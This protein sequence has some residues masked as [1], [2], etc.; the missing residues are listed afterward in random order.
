LGLILSQLLTA[1]TSGTTISEKEV[2][3]RVDDLLSKMTLQEKINQMAQV[4]AYALPGTP[5]L[6]P[7]EAALQGIGSIL[8][9]KDPV[10][11]NKLQH[12]AVEQSRMH[13][14]VLF[15]LDVI[16][17]F[18]TIF[19]APLTMAASWD[20]TVAEK[21]QA[22]AAR[23]ARASGIAWTFAPMVDIARD[24][25]WGRIIEGAGEDPYLGAAMARAQVQG[26][27]GDNLASPDHVLACAKHFAGYGAPDGGR[28]YDSVYI[29]EDQLW[30][31]YFPPFKAAE[32]A[33]VGSFMSAY[34]DLNNVPATGNRFLMH[35]VLRDT[36]GFKG[37][38]VSDAR[39]VADLV[40]H[41]FA[42]DAEDAAYRAATAGVN[43]DMVGG[44]YYGN[45]EKL[46][47]AGKIKEPQID[48]LT[49]PILAAKIRLGL[50]EHPYVD[51]SLHA[52]VVS[53]HASTNMARWAAQRSITLLRNE[54]NI[55]PL[56]KTGKRISSLAVIGP[57][58]DDRMAQMSMWGSGG[59]R[60]RVVTVIE[61]IRNF[62]GDRV[63]VEYVKGPN[64]HRQIPSY[65]G[66]MLG[67]DDPQLTPRQ[68]QEEI[69]KAVTVAKNCDAVVVVLGETAFLSGES[70]ARS[71]LEL[72]GNQEDLLKAVVATGKPVV[73]VLING[74]PLD[75]SWAAENVSAIVEAGIPGS[76]GGD[77]IADALFGDINPGGKLPVTW[78][79]HTGQVPIYYAHNLS[80]VPEGS[81]IYA[82]R[83]SDIPTTPLYPF[84]YGLSYTTFSITDLKIDSPATK[85]GGTVTASVEVE[86]TGKIAGDEVVQLYIHQRAGQ[87]SRPV[88]ELKGFR[89]ITLA[90]GEK[91]SVKFTLGKDELSYW[92]TIEK[93]WVLEPEHF[94]VWVGEDSTAKLHGEFALT[95]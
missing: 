89:R 85:V 40:T 28:D 14:P 60:K 37:F 22:V 77:A 33:G 45:L 57:L 27:Q 4:G 38:V 78:P 91:R 93:K 95:K 56:D 51:E 74:R 88:R 24:A 90:R 29:S 49:R 48:E 72:P 66:R 25:R 50:F 62:L 59:D 54:G 15:G 17:G 13:I 31:V 94:D 1:Q 71:T 26:F 68:T 34:M 23:E 73:L 6:T 41:G 9:V 16:H 10:Q 55:L 18:D 7:D 67:E 70:A 46:V 20:P 2:R 63:R 86:N 39:A 36:W 87:A 81:P 44:I 47:R 35:D 79:L 75:I 5:S 8:W 11:I 30:N 19:P 92:S 12:I 58:A 64:V 52:Q 61:G 69:S 42:H 65:F 76:E 3:V 84:G 80:N 53:D 32:E 21:G 43:M 83:Y 82:G